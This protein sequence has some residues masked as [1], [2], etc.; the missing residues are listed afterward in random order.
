MY[1]YTDT[2]HDL[3]SERRRTRSGGFYCISGFVVSFS[4]FGALLQLLQTLLFIISFIN[5]YTKLNVFD[6]AYVGAPC[7][8]INFMAKQ[9]RGFPRENGGKY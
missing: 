5:I 3:L 7:F 6:Y 4:A 2:T 8:D 1:N 9:Q